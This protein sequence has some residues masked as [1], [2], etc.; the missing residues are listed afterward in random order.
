MFMSTDN[1][2][3]VLSPHVKLRLPLR[4]D[5]GRTKLRSRGA[6]C[7]D[8]HLGHAMLLAP[9]SARVSTKELG[10]VREVHFANLKMVQLNS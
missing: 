10:S 5:I 7:R 8:A 9:L 1:G 3:G 2:Y 4:V 6:W